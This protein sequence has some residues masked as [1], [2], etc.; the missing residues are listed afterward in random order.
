MRRILVLFVLLLWMH[1]SARGQLFTQVYPDEVFSPTSA[2]VHWNGDTTFILCNAG[3]IMR[4][5]DAGQQ[6]ENLYPAGYEWNFYQAVRSNDVV[7]ILAE[8]TVWSDADLPP[9]HFSALLRYDPRKNTIDIVEIPPLPGSDTSFTEVVNKFQIDA[10]NG[11]LFLLQGGYSKGLSL[12]R[13]VNDGLNWEAI[14][15]PDSI[16]EWDDA[17]IA[18]YDRDRF[19]LRVN[20][21]AVIQHGKNVIVTSNGGMTWSAF[22]PFTLPSIKGS[23]RY[24]RPGIA[25]TGRDEVV[26]FSSVGELRY[27]NDFGLTW[28]HRAYPLF[29]DLTM[30]QSAGDGRGYI[31]ADQKLYRSDDNFTSFIKILDGEFVKHFMT[32]GMDTIIVTNDNDHLSVSYN[33]G[34]SWDVV[35]RKSY[36]IKEI[37]MATDECGIA[38][39]RPFSANTIP[40]LAY[41]LTRDGWNTMEYLFDQTTVE[42][43]ELTI[44]PFTA[45]SWYG[46]APAVPQRGVVLRRSTDQ[47]ASWTDIL[48]NLQKPDFKGGAL[49][50]M[51]D[52]NYVG[53]LD[54]RMLLYSSDRGDSWD[55]IAL[56][57]YSEVGGSQFTPG[58]VSWI[59]LRGEKYRVQDTVL[60]STDKWITWTR[61][62][63]RPENS[64]ITYEFLDMDVLKDG[65]CLMYT[66][67]TQ[68]LTDSFHFLRSK[69]TGRTWQKYTADVGAGGNFQNAVYFEDGSAISN[70]RPATTSRHKV[71]GTHIHRST[72]QW[73]TSQLQETRYN[74][75]EN[76]IAAGKSSIYLYGASHIVRNSTGGVNSV[77]TKLASPLSIAVG[78]PFPHPV[79]RGTQVTIPLEIAASV[80]GT[81]EVA[82]TDM[83]GR[84]VQRIA[85][86]PIDG[87]NVSIPWS[88]GDI[89]TG[90]YV[91]RISVGEYSGVRPVVI[92]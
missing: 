57:I 28:G 19:A 54:G 71:G 5:V 22:S 27:S 90:V 44:T 35:R 68:Q 52:T 51:S 42:Y 8:P 86:H 55:S 45:W 80:R 62:L 12:H 26:A 61:V 47:G 65:T 33:G 50:Q 79:H 13:S 32:Y 76:L 83:L 14:A 9:G 69:D 4:S 63:L 85:S 77:R 38:L 41:Y 31:L 15:L 59:W 70:G 36:F 72:D 6:W 43:G 87:V 78:S 53:V 18:C 20:T 48:S 29:A 88:V 74:A 2:T 73:E 92:R 58:G 56:P 25:W 10:G 24:F 75:P 37:R 84:R 21:N 89:A 40:T 3:L 30:L 39:L 11:A 91:L 34:I 64:D 49:I 60:I 17:F 66:R 81:L 82:L 1:E 16:N 67:E 46:R 7:I 23:K